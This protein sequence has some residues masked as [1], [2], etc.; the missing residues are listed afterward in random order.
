MDN[1]EKIRHHLQQ[2]HANFF[3]KTYLQ[4]L[5]GLTLSLAL[6]VALVA[7]A[8]MIAY[9]WKRHLPL[10]WAFLVA[11]VVSLPWIFW[12]EVQVQGGTGR[13]VVEEF[14]AAEHANVNPPNFAHLGTLGAA[15]ARQRTPISGAMEIF[16]LG[17]NL[18]IAA[19]RKLRLRRLSESASAD[20]IA[21][22]TEMLAK[23]KGGAPPEKILEPPETPAELS[24][25]LAYLLFFDWIG[26]AND[27]T[28]VWL[29]TEARKQLALEQQ[30]EPRAA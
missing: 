15:L 8:L 11:A 10:D 29:L 20:R 6:P 27:G 14:V 4:V 5:L 13:D 1:L 12:T 2:R 17:P 22:V 16:H 26:V 21:R 18:V 9:F 28:K 24:E 3:V 30:P 19:A 25:V 7:F 23:I